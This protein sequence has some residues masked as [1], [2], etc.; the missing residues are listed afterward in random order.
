MYT[1]FLMLPDI[2]QEMDDNI[3]PVQHIKA[4]SRI[5][6]SQLC[7]FVLHKVQEAENQ[8]TDGKKWGVMLSDI[9]L[10]FFCKQGKR[11]YFE[12]S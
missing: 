7:K 6:A 9:K 11:W 10:Y 8:R 1:E 5:K 2:G 3:L 4:Q 12:G